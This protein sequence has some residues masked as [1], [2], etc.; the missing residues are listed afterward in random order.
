M[1]HFEG[2]IKTILE[3]HGYWVR[4]SFKVDLTRQEKREIG[5]PSLPRPEID[6]LALKHRENKILAL[7]AKSYLDSGGIHLDELQKRYDIP[8][9]RYKLFT[10]YKYQSILLD[11]L[12]ENLRNFGMADMNTRIILG[13]VAGKVYRSDSNKVQEYFNMNNWFFWGPD[14][15]KHKLSELSHS[16]YENDP[17]IITA[18]I[19]MR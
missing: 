3:H 15:I 9:G 12:M 14:D 19:L 6:L 1:N 13:L 16:R 18:K 17:A 2:I 5:K 4:Q 11:R 8:E 7:E 10:C